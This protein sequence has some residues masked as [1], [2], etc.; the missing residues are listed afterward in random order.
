DLGTGKEQH[1]TITSNTN[2][3]KEDVEKAVQEAEQYAEEDKKKREA[4]EI[5]N[6][7][8]YPYFD[9]CYL[10][11]EQGLKKPDP[12]IFKRCMDELHLTAEECI[13]VGDG[14]SQELEASG[15]LGMKPLQAVW[16]FK[17]GTLHR[18]KPMEGYI[19]LKT[20]MNVLHHI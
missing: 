7:V 13:F 8:L 17:E 9:V 2:M 12:E 15:S 19:H 16:Y 20:P 10:S 14:G 18:I 11:Y 3:S 6:S 4:V 1:I 5:R